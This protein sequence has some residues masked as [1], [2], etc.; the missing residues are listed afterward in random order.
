MGALVISLIT[1]I[2]NWLPPPHVSENR[3]DIIL[4]VFCEAEEVPLLHI[5]RNTEGERGSFSTAVT[6]TLF[7]L[8][9]AVVIN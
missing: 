4:L 1:E 9:L 8:L 7:E 6:K 3:A 2:K 5:L